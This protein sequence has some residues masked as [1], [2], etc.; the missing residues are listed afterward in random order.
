MSERIIS[1][2][3]ILEKLGVGGM[4]VVYK[5]QDTRLDRLVALKFLPEDVAK[6]AQALARFRREAKAASALNHPNICTIYDIGEENSQAYIVMEHLDGNTLKHAI[7]TQPMEMEQLLVLAVEIADALDAAHAKGIVHRDI[8]PANIFVTE[9]EH[10][11]ILDFGLAKVA[12]PPGAGSEVALDGETRSVDDQHLT[13]PGTTLGTVAYMSPEQV[14]GKELDSRT[15]LFSFGAVLYEMATGTLA[16]RGETSGLVFNAILERQPAQAVRLNPEVPARLEEIINKCLEKDR[17]LRYQHASDLRADLKRLKRDTDS[18]RHSG[19]ER[20][21]EPAAGS[22]SGATV[23]SASGQPG[24]QMSANPSSAVA[25]GPSVVSG[26][27]PSNSGMQRTDSAIVMDAVSRNKTTVIGVGVV[28]LLLLVAAGYGIFHASRGSGGAAPARIMQISHWNKGMNHPVMSPDGNAVAFTSEAGGYQQIFVMLTSG[29]EPLQITNDEDNKILWNFSGDSTRIYY[30]RQ[31]GG[32]ETWSV[33]TLGGTATH[34]GSGIGFFPSPDHKSVFYGDI[35]KGTVNQASSSGGPGQVIFDAKK[36][37]V[38]P[39]NALVYPDSANLL[40]L[41]GNLAAPDSAEFQLSKLNIA[42]HELTKM[43]TVTGSVGSVVW[44]EPGKTLLMNRNVNGLINLWEYDLET[45]KFKQL[46]TGAGPDFSPMKDPGGKGIYFVNGK[47]SG[48]LSV[49]DTRAKSSSDIGGDFPAQPT[50]SRDG[51]Q[52]MY[53]TTPEPGRSELWVSNVDGGQKLKL[54][55]GKVIST[56]DW[57]PDN[58]ELTY[59]LSDDNGKEHHYVVRRDGS[60]VRELPHPLARQSTD[61]FT[62]DGKEIY[63]SGLEGENNFTWR[64]KE[65][66]SSPELFI[67]GCGLVI[68]V[69]PDGKYLLQTSISGD[70]VGIFAL[71]IADKECIPIVPNVVSF[72]PRFS[73][74]GKSI[75]FT[76]SERGEVIVNR[77]GWSD[78]KA[79]GK[80][81]VVAKLPFAFAQ[82]GN[83]NVYDIARDLSRIV[84]V[85]PSGQFDLYLLSQK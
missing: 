54:S 76:E 78:G 15:D 3:R 74:D 71:R 41:L 60:H 23:A 11:K 8:K 72:V 31:L 70:R 10:A 45:K 35:G 25:S 53:V 29:G 62:P 30:R 75:L 28:I 19:S 40:L 2:Y 24:S 36:A 66:G 59:L 55:A 1:H 50:F 44:G 58:S 46:T 26:V 81:Q 63:L 68:D 4:G 82:S 16:F 84:Y 83:G 64:H 21:L 12:G 6:D 69:S 42:S 37:G 79:V 57:S 32:N 77:V 47:R 61:A 80:S 18:G 13:S 9:R 67:K 51:K 39:F 34:F 22:G 5:A 27:A 33:P 73:S 17:D 65:D 56:A 20:Q 85:R 14:K 48:I 38:A 43:E 52:V 7:G 49:Y